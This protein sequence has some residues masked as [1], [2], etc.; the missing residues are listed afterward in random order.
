MSQV[1]GCVAS[2]DLLAET[3]LCLCHTRVSEQCWIVKHSD[4]GA[5][6]SSSVPCFAAER[7]SPHKQGQA[8]AEVAPISVC[9]LL[10]KLTIS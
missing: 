8:A 2:Q 3:W 7:S 4:A 1:V 6:A 10:Q 9:L 5:P